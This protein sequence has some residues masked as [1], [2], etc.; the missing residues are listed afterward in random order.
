MISSVPIE[1]QDHGRDQ[2]HELTFTVR[3]QTVHRAC[4]P[5]PAA[6][7][8]LIQ[9]ADQAQTPAAVSPPQCESRSATI[10]PSD[11][12]IAGINSFAGR[13]VLLDS[14]PSTT[15]MMPKIRPQ[16]L[17]FA[18]SL[19]T[20]GSG[21]LTVGS[22]G[23]TNLSVTPSPPPFRLVHRRSAT[24]HFQKLAISLPRLHGPSD[25]A[26]PANEHRPPACGRRR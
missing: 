16:Y 26:S 6:A 17:L 24:I 9:A 21:H 10:G 1:A 13:R 15:P 7:A 23:S 18:A 11:S 5:R 2:N 19:Q 20:R 12:R 22:P 25:E 8:R 14:A 4:F 3:M